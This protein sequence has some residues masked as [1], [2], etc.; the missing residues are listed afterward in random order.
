MAPTRR[1]AAILFTDMVGFT[2]A[3]QR[4][5]A[6]A[7]ELLREQEQ[8]VRPIVKDHRGRV[9]KSTGDGFLIEF[10][11]GLQAAE[12]AVQIQTRLHD[13]NSTSK[14][15]PIQLRIGIHVGDV[16]AREADIFGDAVNVAARV[17]STAEP[18]GIAVTEQVA[19]LLQNRLPLPLEAL[20]AK[21]FKGVDHPVQVFRVVLPWS[22]PLQITEDRTY[23][24][25]AI[26]P[27]RNISP[28]ANDEYFADGLTEELISSLGQVRELR[29]IARSSVSR[30]RASDRTLPEIGRELG[31][32]A[33]LEGSVRKAGDRLRISLQ[34]VDV[35][36]QENLWTQT[37]DR[38][39]DDVF[40]VQAEV[41]E[42]TAAA[43][44]VRMLGAQR[45]A[46]HQ[47]PTRNLAAYGL[48]LQG[49]HLS[50]SPRKEDGTA[51]VD[52]F[53][54]AIELDPEFSAA[55]S[56]LAN[57]LLGAIGE[58]ASIQQILPKARP[59]VEKA[60]RLDPESPEAHTA[61]GN[62]AMQGDLDWAIAEAEF[63]RALALNPSDYDSRLWYG[64]LLRSL[65]RYSDAEEQARVIME[66]DPLNHAGASLLTSI[67]RLAGNFEEAEQLTRTRL[68][69]LLSPAEYHMS[70]A[71][72]LLYS[73]RKE[74]AR[75]EHD[76][77]FTTEDAYV[78]FDGAVLLARLGDP[79]PAQ[80]RLATEEKLA[81]E[82]YVPLNR[83]AAL[84]SAIGET[85]RAIAYLEKDWAEGDRGLWF[86][87]QGL[88]FDPV[89]SDPRF[90]RMLERMRLPTSAP[91]FRH[92]RLT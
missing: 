41:G 86:T 17:L 51:A 3:A 73:G 82:T 12:C 36:S 91:F 44:R 37:F 7:L 40:A 25:V 68:R 14:L 81:Q 2:S 56:H 33:V 60:L 57:R 19:H 45:A 63:R 80:S 42:R 88:A 55:Y 1:L 22:S 84:A 74:E 39:L 50:R 35:A 43:L 48:Y 13:R 31:A 26:L 46:L 67:L 10:P 71:Y 61:K 34:L 5:E 90:I 30:L 23:P 83:L 58:S 47:P 79:D 4:H 49:I 15:A 70:L 75:M 89:R 18:Q 6:L 28:D 62:L 66:L 8:L 16:E 87:Y 29:V 85:D 78:S 76:Q 24:R 32:S 27:L 77:A 38:R 69:S 21:G 65:Q 20:G 72:T 59:L 54:R 9:I 52:L 64:L 53:R 11:S 92:G